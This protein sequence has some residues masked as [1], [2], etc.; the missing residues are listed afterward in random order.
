M[1][2]NCSCAIVTLLVGLAF[3]S[4]TGAQ[5]VV[6]GSTKKVCQVLGQFD[7]ELGIPTV[8]QTET[9]FGLY[10]TDLGSSFEFDG[11][12]W[13]LFGDSVPDATFNGQDNLSFRNP[14][15]NDSIASGTT[16]NPLDC[17]RL[18]FNT[19][20]PIS[21]YASPVI[22][23]TGAPVTLG[24]FEVPVAGVDL[25]DVMF[26]FFATGYDGVNFS[27]KSVVG[28][29]VDRGLNFQYLYTF[30]SAKF[31]N[32][33][34]AQTKR[35]AGSP[36]AGSGQVLWIWGTPGGAGYRNSNPYLAV[37][38]TRALPTGNRTLYYAGMNAGTH[39]PIFSENE[40]DAATLFSDSPACMGELGVSWNRYL[41]RWI[42]L[43]NCQATNDIV[44]RS[45]PKPWGPWSAPQTI[46][47][48]WA[49]GGY[50]HFIHVAWTFEDC[51]NVNDPGRQ[52]VW[53]GPYGPYV[54][55]RLTRGSP[56]RTT[57]YYILSTWNP[58]TTVLMKSQIESDRPRP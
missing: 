35:I 53:G 55:D 49:D 36:I 39:R 43:Y 8:N 10:G 38:P 3:A 29:S 24:N 13:F 22:H 34:T 25:S 44:M 2:R 32:I 19:G 30:S 16:T 48:P 45:A 57:I 37:M 4:T 21:A 31:V 17:I 47:D 11:M 12:P 51:D 15:Y 52:D 20:P 56:G 58:Y 46:F 26:V 1:S 6:A 40:S 50:C 27:T 23:S 5:T 54:V 18:N 42:M 9:R 33:Q 14:D 7:R 28:S 41:H